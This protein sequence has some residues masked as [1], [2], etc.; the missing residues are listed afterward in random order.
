[1][2]GFK[3]YNNALQALEMPLTF[4]EGSKCK[5]LLSVQ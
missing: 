1:M 3:S 2:I 4:K 5:Q